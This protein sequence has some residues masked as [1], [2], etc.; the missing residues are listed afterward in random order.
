MSTSS[1]TAKDAKRIR[2]SSLTHVVWDEDTP[3]LATLFHVDKRF[4]S[5]VQEHSFDKALDKVEQEI[6]DLEAKIAH[7][8]DLYF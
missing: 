5:F 6:A 1:M 3:C 7:I 8:E 4:K 2:E